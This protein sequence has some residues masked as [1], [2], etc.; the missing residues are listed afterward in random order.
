MLYSFRKSFCY[1]VVKVITN[2]LLVLLVK[3]CFLIHSNL[4]HQVEEMT[5]WPPPELMNFGLQV[6]AFLKDFK[7]PQIVNE[8]IKNGRPVQLQLLLSI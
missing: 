1:K 4:I 2:V 7:K 6:L 8:N 3:C 5:L